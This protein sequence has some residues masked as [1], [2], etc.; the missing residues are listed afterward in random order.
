MYLQ[1]LHG[2]WRKLFG[3]PAA[4]TPDKERQVSLGRGSSAG[5]GEEGEGEEGESGGQVSNQTAE[6]QLESGIMVY[7]RRVSSQQDL[8]PITKVQDLFSW[9]KKTVVKLSML[10]VNVFNLTFYAYL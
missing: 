2:L 1:Q 8:T 7:L 6:K 9:A 10:S 3:V 5:S 4:A